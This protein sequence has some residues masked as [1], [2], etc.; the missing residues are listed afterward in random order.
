MKLPKIAIEN[1]QF[2]IIIIILLIMFGLVSLITMPRTEDPQISPAGSSVIAVYPGANPM[3]MEEL[4][5]D[6]VEEVLNE[7]EDIKRLRGKASDNLAN[8]EIEFVSGSD[9]DE[10]YS[11]VVQKVNSIRDD[12]P[13]DLVSL[14]IIKWSIT[15]VY[16][17]QLAFVSDHMSYADMEKE[18]ERLKKE[19]EKLYGVKRVKIFATPEQE[20]RISLDL[21]KLAQYR[22]PIN[23]VIESLQAA[24]QNI[25]GGNLDIGSKRYNIKTS[26]SLE[27]L[28]DIG[29][30]II[31]G[32]N[33]NILYLRN[34]ADIDYNHEDLKYKA[35]FN[36]KR[37]IFLNVT[38]KA[39][40][41]IFDIS[42]GLNSKLQQF[43][44]N[45]PPVLKIET[46]FDQSESVHNRVSGF[47]TNLLQGLLLVGF[48]V[49][50][51]VSIRASMIVIIVIPISILT[52]IGLLDLSNYGLQQMTIS[53]FV[54]ALGL[55]VDNAIVVTE[56]IARYMRLG[57][58]PKDAAVK[59][60]S[61]IAWAI[62]SSTVTTILAFIPMM[63][64]GDV[65]GD[66]IRS[67]PV[68]V[69]YTLIASLFISLTLTPYLSSKF[70]TIS[71]NTENKRVRKILNK[72][73]ESEYRKRRD[74]GLQ[75]PAIVLSI[76]VII[77]ALSLSLFNA[78]GVTFF[79]KAEKPQFIVNVWAPE[80]TS[81][82]KTE[83]FVD[84]VED[85]LSQN[86]EVVS[87]ASNIG[88]GNPRIYYNVV[89]E[90]EKSHHA[91]ILVKTRDY[92]PNNFS[93]RIQELRK[94]F[95]RIPGVRIEVKEFE[96]GP[97]VEA[98]IA[99]RLFG[100]NLDKL[101]DIAREIENLMIN[102]E[103]TVNVF[104]PLST[105]K[106]DLWVK[107]DRDKA[108]MLGVPLVYIDQ[109]VRLAINGLEV[110]DF[111]DKEGK[112]YD[113]ILRLP[114]DE[115]PRIE[116][117]NKIYIASM[118]G[119][120][121]PLKQL[122]T[123][124]FKK[125]PM[126]IDHYDLERQVTITSDVI[127]EENVNHVT[128]AVISQ[129]DK[130]EWQKGYYYSIGGEQESRQESFGGM[131][132]A[133]LVA[134]LGIFAVLVLQFRSYIQP[135]IVFSAIPLAIIGSILAL[136]ITGYSFSFSAFIGLT[137]LV[138]IV[139]NN[140]IILVDYTN[141]LRQE[142]KSVIEALKEATEVR[143]IPIVLTTTTTIGGLL[144]LTLGGGT[145][146]APMGW[147]IIG[148]LIASTFLTLMVVPVLY[149]LFVKNG[150]VK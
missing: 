150:D 120:Q 11:D 32:A 14:D 89:P 100:E 23:R 115:K 51:A 81:L 29:N 4:V 31:H 127:G 130:M 17:L 133:V 92:D 72:I 93:Q 136:L 28:D 114:V 143:F 140:S 95:S 135:L 104:N 91:Q 55:L 149:K 87:Y 22:I 131:M 71:D 61:E 66:F 109:A 9:P 59:G 102:T 52:G 108:G 49:L 47:F 99:I 126:V 110:T 111:R 43:K 42:D 68:T 20:V 69:V 19:F 84:L 7:L 80:G 124:E 137:S 40:T 27:S 121:I 36:G 96:Q 54:I 129:L 141:Q 13:D 33:G 147:T 117:F 3:D 134:V 94:K 118:M 37:A 86:E 105:S 113:V 60:T 21:Q 5:V 145:L 73:I 67:M 90:R 82:D 75:K 41:N 24:N 57:F 76:I 146:W 138:G 26:G 97:P 119:A 10:K 25:P 18:A 70:L 44:E 1:H 63:M 144:P 83:K 79:P 62:V 2:T 74:Y 122:A 148:G 125:T 50:L 88:Y 116:N 56:N 78:V 53:G 132:K 38:Q 98:P 45:I 8:I 48:V 16:I 65:T 106:T 46:V 12:L 123:I 112:D 101:R 34:V 142:G 15:D 77:F 64:I 139:V 39:G 107:I 6:P 128:N 35:R 103:G 85:E 30:I 58:T